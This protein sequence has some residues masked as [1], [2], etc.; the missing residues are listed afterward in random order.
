MTRERQTQTTRHTNTLTTRANQPNMRTAHHTH[1][2]A[3]RPS[4]LRKEDCDRLERPRR[5]GSRGETEQ[6]PQSLDL[7]NNKHH[8]T[9]NTPRRRTQR[10]CVRVRSGRGN[11]PIHTRRPIR[12]HGHTGNHAPTTQANVGT[13][14]TASTRACA[15]HKRQRSTH[16]QSAEHAHHARAMAPLL[17]PRTLWHT[18]TRHAQN[19]PQKP[20]PRVTNHAL[21]ASLPRITLMEARHTRNIS[22][23]Q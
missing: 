22:A 5:A 20:R 1:T 18:T 2:S 17:P 10:V 12:S 19:Q 15:A 7:R 6:T 14:D 9:L 11:K 4:G 13:L 23:K 21:R 3:H 16:N 8:Q